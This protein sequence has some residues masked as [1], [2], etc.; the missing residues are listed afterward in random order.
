MQGVDPGIFQAAAK[1]GPNLARGNK[2]NTET[3]RPAAEKPTVLVVDDEEMIANT[4]VEIL[5]RFGFRAVFAYDGKTAL[6]IAA[7]LKPDYLLTD[8][9]MPGINGVELAIAISQ[10]LPA[11][12]ILLISGQAG[13][14]DALSRA[15]RKGYSFE[16]LA[17]PIH[18][19][20]LMERLKRK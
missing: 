2:R 3:E 16:L 11:T 7:K 6:E 18:P 14:S 4:T 9:L 10:M 19:E 13:V 8:V 1:F 17:K 12:K 15:E 5:N 20:R